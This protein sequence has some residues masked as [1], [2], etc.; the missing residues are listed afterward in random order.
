M[1][2][3]RW[4]AAGGRRGQALV[5]VRGLANDSW[6]CSCSRRVM[7]SPACQLNPVS[8]APW[9]RQDGI[10]LS[11]VVVVFLKL[12]GCRYIQAPQLDG[13]LWWFWGFNGGYGCSGPYRRP[14]SVCGR[15]VCSNQK[16][17]EGS[18]EIQEEDGSRCVLLSFMLFCC[19]FCDVDLR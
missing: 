15:F 14:V 4:P 18:Q 2:L 1:Q 8:E 9:S 17:D 13:F 19:V 6:L 16:Q 5:R 3:S 10:F 7:C 12:C 11:D